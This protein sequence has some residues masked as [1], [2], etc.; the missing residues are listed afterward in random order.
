MF[1]RNYDNYFVALNLCPYGEYNTNYPCGGS[2]SMSSATFEY[3]DGAF[4]QK[5]TNGSNVSVKLA[6][7]MT[8]SAGDTKGPLMF[9][10][11][12]ICLG[13]GTTPVTYDDYR[14]SGDVIPNKLAMVSKDRTYDFNTHRWTAT[15]TATY[16]NTGDEAITISEWGI[17]R[18][19]NDYTTT[20]FSNASTT[21][22]LVFREV[23][24]EPIVIEPGTTATLT[25]SV[26]IPMPNHP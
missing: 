9:N 7:T 13:T 22:C 20:A 6:G 25:F 4:V 15:L 21:C 17:W 2:P 3:A 1:L 11:N 5:N 16:S 18:N 8:S 19:N 10:K 26:E 14:L 12:G 24:D 23:L